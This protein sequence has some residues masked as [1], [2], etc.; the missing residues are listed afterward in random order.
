MEFGT[1]SYLVVRGTAELGIQ[2]E[3]GENRL[4]VLVGGKNWVGDQNEQQVIPRRIREK[5]KM[6]FTKIL[7][8]CDMVLAVMALVRIPERHCVPTDSVFSRHVFC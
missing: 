1:E 6:K 4:R 7:L 8:E 5:T 2:N 3:I